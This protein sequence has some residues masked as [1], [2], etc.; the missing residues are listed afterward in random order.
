MKIAWL[1]IAIGSSVCILPGDAS[2][3][4]CIAYVGDYDQPSVGIS[5]P[6]F[7]GTYGECERGCE[8]VLFIHDWGLDGCVGDLGETRL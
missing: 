7:P 6:L 8:G 1:I 4:E 5:A 3:A 2:A